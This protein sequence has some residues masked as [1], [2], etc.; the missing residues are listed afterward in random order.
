MDDPVATANQRSGQVDYRRV[1]PRPKILAVD[2]DP[3]VLRL[4][5]ATLGAEYELSFASDAV[6]AVSTA[7]RVQPDLI[8]LDYRLPGGDGALVIDRLRTMSDLAYVP[9]ILM[10]GW[11]SPWSWEQLVELQLACF[12]PKPFE[13]ETLREEIERALAPITVRG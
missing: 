7:R 13:V 10:S 8:L 3:A 11:E 2:D 1:G 5:A 12:I 6:T 9:V 4:L